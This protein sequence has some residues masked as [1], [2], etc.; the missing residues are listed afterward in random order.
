MNYDYFEDARIN[1]PHKVPEYAE[2]VTDSNVKFISEC[3]TRLV[4]ERYPTHALYKVSDDSIRSAMWQIF[5]NDIHH[6]QVMIQMAI[7]LLTEQ[8]FLQKELMDVSEYDP[9]ILYAP[10]LVGLSS[11]N[12]TMIQLNNKKN[13]PLEFTHFW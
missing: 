3:I 12:P 9:R 7:N 5:S 13:R 1:T 4:K 8:V 10:E 6:T 2:Y 11:V